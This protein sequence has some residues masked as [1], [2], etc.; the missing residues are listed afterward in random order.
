MSGDQLAELVPADLLKAREETS[1]SE[2]ASGRLVP[3]TAAGTAAL[4]TA[5]WS[6]LGQDDCQQAAPRMRLLLDAAAE[7]GNFISPTVS[8][9]WAR[10][11]SP[12]L[13]T[14]HVAGVGPT[15]RS[16]D[17]LRYRSAAARPGSP[18]ADLEMVAR[19]AVKTR[20]CSGRAG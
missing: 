5:A 16:V 12:W 7:R 3:V 11:A 2:S 9:P 10:Y 19:R 18:S 6:I 15:L 4:I 8:R 1:A 14:V 13:H 20:R 17:Q